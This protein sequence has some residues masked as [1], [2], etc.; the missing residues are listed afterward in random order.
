MADDTELLTVTQLRRRW[1]PIKER[2]RAQR[3]DNPTAIRVHRSLSWLGCAEQ[4]DNDFDLAL[5][6][7]WVAF[8]ALYGQ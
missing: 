6:T 2:L 4:A 8:N 3:S 5:L 1:V 7:Q